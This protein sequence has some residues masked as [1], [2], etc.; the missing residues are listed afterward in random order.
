MEN[1]GTARQSGVGNI[2][3]KLSRINCYCSRSLKGSIG[4]ELYW[5]HAPKTCRNFAELV[6]ETAGVISL[7]FL[8]FSSLGVNWLL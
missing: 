7:K 3:G 5:K 8:Y 1:G 4:I 6:R 2:N